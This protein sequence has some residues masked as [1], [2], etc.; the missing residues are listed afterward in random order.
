MKDLE[1]DFAR[2][3]FY[4]LLASTVRPTGALFPRRS[5]IPENF[6][7]VECH[8][9]L[10]LSIFVHLQARGQQAASRRGFF[11]SGNCIPVNF[12]HGH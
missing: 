1:L 5:S 10:V 11:P 7:H 9:L 8:I 3:Q 2:I 12:E 4:K 6:G